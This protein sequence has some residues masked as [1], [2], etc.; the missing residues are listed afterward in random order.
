MFLVE[1]VEVVDFMGTVIQSQV[2]Q[3]VCM[4]CCSDHNFTVP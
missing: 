3:S 4:N 1:D 2:L